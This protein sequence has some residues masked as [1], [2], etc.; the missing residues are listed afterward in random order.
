MKILVI[1]DNPVNMKLITSILKKFG[2]EVYQAEEAESGIAIAKKELP[3]LIFMDIQLPKM[4]G[5]EATKLLKSDEGTRNIKIVA[6]TAFAMKDDK[7]RAL[8]AGCDG[9]ISKPIRYKEL[10]DKINSLFKESNE[11]SHGSDE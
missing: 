5:L 9:Y 11:S 10:L 3:S 7:E 8:Q 1:E 4:D 2:Y 6:L